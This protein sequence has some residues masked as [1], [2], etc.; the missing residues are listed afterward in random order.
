M[1]KLLENPAEAAIPTLAAALD[2]A[3]LGR[4]L[5][6]LGWDTSHGIRV[7]VLEWKPASR[8]TFEIALPDAQGGESRELIG[9]VYAE[10]RSDV[11]RAMEEIRQAG[12]GDEGEFGIPR[13]V[14]FVRHLRLLLYE[15]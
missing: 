5:D 6:A 10:D 13:P 14:A 7:R 9:K 11:Y 2:P 12:F 15:K 1:P 4:R 3:E 8:C